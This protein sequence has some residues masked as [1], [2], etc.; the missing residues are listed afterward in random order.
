MKRLSSI[1]PLLLLAVAL[2]TS[3]RREAEVVS[4]D[5]LKTCPAEYNKK[6]VAVEAY[7]TLNPATG[8]LHCLGDCSIEVNS[9]SANG[10][11]RVIALVKLGKG[12]NQI[13]ESPEFMHSEAV[14]PRG[15]QP[16]EEHMRRFYESLRVRTDDGKVVRLKD[17]V[18][19]A[20]KMDV[21]QNS[22]VCFLEVERIE[23]P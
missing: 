19:L 16:D 17:K 21:W 2:L 7:F 3:C 15:P 8:I 1:A 12:P 4:F 23:Q 18:K 5:K 10:P 20:G 6:D 9:G 22:D 11:R 13:E 14:A